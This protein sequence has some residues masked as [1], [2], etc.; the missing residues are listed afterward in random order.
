MIRHVVTLAAVVLGFGAVSAMPA[1]AAGEHCQTGAYCLF[2]ATNY[3]GVSAVVASGS[4]CHAVASL[5]FPVARSAARG[6]GD[7]YALQLYADSSCTTS[8]GYLNSDVPD[9]SAQGY[10]LILIPG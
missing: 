8:L 2:S 5:G 4:G 7:S 3:S 9:T 1:S 10:R 6:F